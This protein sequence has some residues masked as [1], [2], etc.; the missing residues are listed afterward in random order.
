MSRSLQAHDIDIIMAMDMLSKA[1]KSIKFLRS[2]HM[3]QNIYISTKKYMEKNNF[4]LQLI[5]SII[6]RR[7]S[8]QHDEKSNDKSIQD[9]ILF[10]K[11]NT[12]FVVLNIISSEL[13][14]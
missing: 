12:Y 6:R 10:Y 1:E 13:K 5:C 4:N 7:V 3:L 11:I 8:R 2:D 14:K 9:P